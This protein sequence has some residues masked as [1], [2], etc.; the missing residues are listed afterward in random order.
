MT[1]AGLFSLGTFWGSEVAN[2]LWQSTLFAAAAW[3]LTIFLRG[4]RARVRYWIWVAVSVKF[5]IPFSLLVSLGGLIDIGRMPTIG[6]T[7]P[8]SPEEWIIIKNINQPFS[9]PASIESSP[10]DIN[11]GSD[12]SALIPV[13]VFSV[14]VFGAMGCLFYWMQK[15][16]E[17]SKIIRESKPLSHGHAFAALLRLKQ[18][19]RIPGHIPLALSKTSIEPGVFGIF[20]P[21]LLMP[22]GMP[23]RLENSELEAILEHEFSHIRCRDN[24][25]AAFH[26]LVESLFWF[27]PMVWWIG[28]RLVHEREKACDEAVLQSGKEPQAYAEG[29]LKVCELYLESP[30]VC[31]SGVIGSNLKT[32]IEGIMKRH[33]GHELTSAKKLLLLGT[34]V[35]ALGTP[36]FIGALTTQPGLAQSQDNPKPSFDVASIKPIDDCRQITEQSPGRFKVLQFAPTFQPGRF[37]GCSSLKGFMSI[38]Y[39]VDRDEIAGGPDWSDSTNY[40]IEAKAE[41]ETDTEVLRLMLQSLLEERF[42]LEFHNETREKPVYALVV[43]DGGHKL[44]QAMDENG[45]PIVSL[46]SPDSDNAKVEEAIRKGLPP[47]A[48]SNAVTVKAKVDPN[49]GIMQEF[50]S[51]ATTMQRFADI[52]KNMVGRKVLDKTGLTG[53]YDIQLQSAVDMQLGGRGFMVMV[54][55]GA[56]APPGAAGPAP[57]SEPSGPSVFTALQEQL[58]LKLEAD[59]APLEHIVIDSVETPSE[60]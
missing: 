19:G 40:K 5:L 35:L 32:R 59:E 29:I 58:G 52:L 18:S 12:R 1:D 38:A 6:P 11:A 21:V 7:S 9:S 49:G 45:N 43:A 2:H 34:C 17:V 28:S 4:N 25:V 53:I 14:W 27:H 24:L 56:A 36:L 57:S 50:T 46:P 30:L 10:E 8:E 20:R 31:V 41:N 15:G 37:S 3:L 16:R 22:F 48:G 54:P 60:N 39:Q 47:P 13:T 51:K 26:M 44:K 55:P 23:D 33:I 42:G